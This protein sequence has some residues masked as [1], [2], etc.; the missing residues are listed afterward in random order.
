VKKFVS[1]SRMRIGRLP[2]GPT[3]GSIFIYID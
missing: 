1:S 2:L 3:R